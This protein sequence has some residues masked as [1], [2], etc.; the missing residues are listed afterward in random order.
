MLFDLPTTEPTEL[1]ADEA[2]GQALVAAARQAGSSLSMGMSVGKPRLKA[3]LTKA[4][5][6]TDADGAWIWRDAWNVSELALSLHL[7]R[8]APV[9]GLDR[10]TGAA[11]VDAL[12]ELGA[13]LPT[14]TVRSDDQIRL[15]QFSTP[16]AYAY[17][18]VRAA[19]I[20]QGDLV[21]EPSAGLG[22]LAMFA[23]AR[24]AKLILNELDPVRAAALKT[25][26]GQDVTQ[27][28]A[29]KIDDRLD[30]KLRPTA[31]VMNPPFSVSATRGAYK[32]TS[33][34]HVLSA[35]RRLQ[36]GG[37]L[38]AIVQ[39]GLAPSKDWTENFY[40]RVLEAGS[41]VLNAEVDGS[42]YKKH[43]TTID[44]RVLVIDKDERGY[45]EP[46][47]RADTLA[48]LAGMVEQLPRRAD[49]EPGTGGG[50]IVPMPP[51]VEARKVRTP[52]VPNAAQQTRPASVEPVR[53]TYT[54]R[55]E[56]DG[57]KTGD[58]LY[59]RYRV[60]RIDIEGAGEHK[61][62]LT[63]SASLGGVR[64]PMP[65][66]Q[67]LLPPSVLKDEL[68]S[69][70]QLE[71]IIYAGD[72]HSRLFDGRYHWDDE[73]EELVQVSD[74]SEAGRQVR[75][76]FFL[77]DGTGVGKG[78]Q[79]A[80]V[81]LDNWLQGRKR[82]IWLSKTESLLEDAKRDWTAL[83][84]RG[85]D[86]HLLK[87]WK[88]SEKIGLQQGI[89]FLTYATLRSISRSGDRRIDQLI[90]WAGEDF[91]GVVAYDECHEMAGALGGEGSRGKTKGSQQGRAGVELQGRLPGARIFYVSATGAT[92]VENL[93]YAVR[94]GLW[95]G[96]G[97]PFKDA[98]G[99]AEN[100]HQGGVAAMEMVCRDLVALGLYVS[101]NLSFEGVEYE[102][103]EHKLTEPQK[104][105]WRTYAEAFQVLHQNIGKTLEAIGVIGE[106]G[107]CLNGN[108]KGQA[109]SAFESMKQRFFGSL[110][111]AAKMPTLLKD[112]EAELAAGKSA[113]V[114]IVTTG[115]AA[116][117]RKL[118]EV[119][120]Q[121]LVERGIDVSP[122]EAIMD[123][124]VHAFPV[125]AHTEH[126][127]ENGK[128]YT[129]PATDANGEAIISQE[130]LRIRQALL[131]RMGMLPSIT[132]ALD[133][134]IWHFGPE[135]VAE[136]TGRS[137]RVVKR[138]DGLTEEIAIEKRGARAGTAETTAFMTGQKKI[139]IFSTAGGT[140][141]S[142]HADLSQPNQDRRAHYLLEP[143]WRA[144]AAVQGLGRT[145][146]TNQASAPLFKPVVTDVKG[147]KRFSSTIARKLDSL[148]ALTKGER[149]T[150]GQGLF[151]PE[152]NLESEEAR[153]ALTLFIA[154]VRAN[155][156]PEVPCAQFEEMTGLSL[157]N[158]DGTEKV[159][160]VP[161]RQ[162]LN[163]IL[164]LPIDVQNVVFEHFERLIANR[165]EAAREAGT[166]D[167]GL[168]V[169]TADH[170]TV[171]SDDLLTTDELSGAETRLVQVERQ[172]RTEIRSAD[173][174]LQ[175]IVGPRLMV[176]KQTGKAAVVIKWD[177]WTHS[178]GS[179]VPRVRLLRPT[180]ALDFCMSVPDFDKSLWREVTEGAFR[181]IWTDEAEAL[182]EMETDRFAL[183]TGL[184]LPLWPLLPKKGS[185]VYRLTTD[186]GRT[187]LGRV[188]SMD[189]A[190]K[191][192]ETFGK[193]LV[194]LS[195]A[196]LTA[197][198]QDG[199]EPQIGKL[200]LRRARVMEDV[201]IEVMG[202]G[203]QDV[204]ALKAAGCF[205]EL[206]AY[207]TRLFV[208]KAKDIRDEVLARLLNRFG[209]SVPVS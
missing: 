137:R 53:I 10:M 104:E 197:A 9:M 44:T 1:D 99:F 4:L 192:S 191:L 190:A 193:E 23:R 147:E 125:Q 95:I 63:Q 57:G 33:A 127:D 122:K 50:I 75:C 42:V 80:G 187:L 25:F 65:S 102:M 15:Q 14:H 194:E 84:G 67:P 132:S 195:P 17:L 126:T 163:R 34:E 107:Q 18:V 142:Y 69:D 173:D 170:M 189:V 90:E 40:A 30:P 97:A 149:K 13:L 123:Y 113:V 28:D 12:E 139:L 48:E 153:D 105:M 101:R 117:E 150:G 208:P 106:N 209:S 22:S 76:G 165:V 51:R 130:A 140:G 124:L 119:S 8:F 185:R 92:V 66:Y 128:V 73:K 71:T 43:G 166:L 45:A 134:L 68:L 182:P 183:V 29:G 20:E 143:G 109:I 74:S 133:Q 138:R 82:A 168:E 85:S 154:M 38:A 136:V 2:K 177:D 100:M 111:T 39:A 158:S 146:R 16:A 205:S 160:G 98:A 178:D 83:G 121:D 145:H 6:G 114:Q 198:L 206:I 56:N 157:R 32:G 188:V 159:E 207:Q 144:D 59:E 162:F 115:E 201:R 87:T 180:E 161:I 24:G 175:R 171:A 61:S 129:K 156:I 27:F 31:V 103:L 70:A 21:L 110:L 79:V 91:E 203:T 5:G 196:D 184:I 167:L 96:S 36:K 72:A 108:A 186:C 174:M 46:P 60:R 152:D 77:G 41:I 199:R 93:A 148:G 64:P 37:R 181:R 155:H 47:V 204:D 35:Y 112:I 55:A 116:L 141:R 176:N 19:M 54:E 172:T 49:L 164:A 7:M 131:E 81:I 3:A 78:R 135:K 58:G 120:P 62:A 202:W 151:R 169:M 11:A 200:R 88:P 86:I 52:I 179:T 26:L 118:A 89:I 94:L